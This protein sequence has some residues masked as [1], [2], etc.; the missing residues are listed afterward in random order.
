M[1]PAILSCIFVIYLYQTLNHADNATD[2]VSNP[3][4]PSPVTAESLSVSYGPNSSTTRQTCQRIR[5]MSWLLGAA[6]CG[7][8]VVGVREIE[9]DSA[10]P[11]PSQSL[12]HRSGRQ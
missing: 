4:Q 1:I 10:F 2:P 8:F 9:V 11:C 6:Y 12:R 5:I 3:N 7:I